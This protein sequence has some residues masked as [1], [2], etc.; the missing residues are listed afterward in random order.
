MRRAMRLRAMV[1][2]AGKNFYPPM[3]SLGAWY[4]SDDIAQGDGSSVSQWPDRSG[5][6]A[7]L[8][9]TP[10]DSP[11]FLNSV[12]SLGN[13]PALQMTGAQQ[14]RLTN[15][16]SYAGGN[17]A[18]SLYLVHDPILDVTTTIPSIAFGWGG[19]GV[20]NDRVTVFIYKVNNEWV[21]GIESY[22]AGSGGRRIPFG[23]QIF[24]ASLAQN[25]LCAQTVITVNG[26]ILPDVDGA[27][28]GPLAIPSPVPSVTLGHFPGSYGAFGYKGKIAEILYYSRQH[29][30]LERDATLA[31]LS[32]RY[33]IGVA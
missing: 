17:S 6:G 15:P 25:A 5:N 12:S 1:S 33:G 16:S 7:N 11:T 32:D 18:Y 10:G 24:N 22:N 4:R 30:D 29:T 26:S 28:G 3:D 31:Y 9:Q 2:F 20:G 27:A 21:C 13:R 19:P 14:L 8:T 23:G